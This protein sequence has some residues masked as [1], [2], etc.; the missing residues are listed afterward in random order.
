MSST[1][2]D[3]VVKC[4]VTEDCANSIKSEAE[5]RNVSTSFVMRER[6]AHPASELKPQNAAQLQNDVNTVRVYCE[7]LEKQINNTAAEETG[8]SMKAEIEIIKAAV[9]DMDERMKKIWKSLK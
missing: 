4:R 2:K 3:Q 8:T 1:N 6:L 7:H 5:K 9:D